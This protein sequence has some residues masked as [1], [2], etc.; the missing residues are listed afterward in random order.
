MTTPSDPVEAGRDNCSSR[1]SSHAADI[2]L[3]SAPIIYHGTPMTPRAALEAVLPGRAGCVSYHHPADAE[4]VEAVCPRIMFRQRGLQ[5]LAGCAQAR[6]GMGQ[7]PARLEALLSV[8]RGAPRARW[9][10]GGDTRHAGSAEPTQRRTLEGLAI[11]FGQGRPPLAY[12]RPAR[13]LGASLRAIQNG[14]AGLDRPSKTRAGR[15]RPLLPPHGRSARSVRERLARN[16]Y[17]ARNCRGLRPSICGGRRDDTS[18]G[19][20]AL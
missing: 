9:A 1:E 15:V 5:L 19:R 12:G 11:R 13:A 16:A 4:A 7:Q 18:T 8:A 20:M 17:D 14:R 3:E 6:R 2:A 10:L